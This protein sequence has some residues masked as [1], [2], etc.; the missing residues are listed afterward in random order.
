MVTS[1]ML[2]GDLTL[3]R[4]VQANSQKTSTVA[5]ALRVHLQPQEPSHPH[6]CVST[7]ALTPTRLQPQ[8]PSLPHACVS[9]SLASAQLTAAGTIYPWAQGVHTP[10]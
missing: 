7:G 2:Q 8:E 6:A 3:V 5:P 4:F 1:S 10:L 9:Q